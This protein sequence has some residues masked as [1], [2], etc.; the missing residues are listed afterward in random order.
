MM[1]APR[2][3]NDVERLHALRALLLLD[4]PPEE[5]FDRIAAFAASEFNVPMAM[6]S[7]VDENRQWLKAQVGLSFCETDRDT[8]FCGH[9]IMAPATMVVPDATRDPR[10][11]DNPFVTGE[12]FVRFYAGAPLSLPSGDIV[13]TLC[14]MDT[15]PRQMDRID[16]AILGALRALVVEE[17]QRREAAT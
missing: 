10:F 14:V 1:K 9:A 7:L 3:G 13:G 15:Q 5:R 2:P 17:M 16:L 6:V 4:T 8:S 11:A 12:P